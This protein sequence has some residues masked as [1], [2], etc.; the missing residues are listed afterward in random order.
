MRFFSGDQ[1]GGTSGPVT[2]SVAPGGQ[3]DVSVSLTAPLTA[4]TYQGN[5]RLADD[6]DITFGEIVDVVIDVNGS[7]Y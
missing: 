4:G 1:M 6:S 3:T 5:W 7:V 2:S